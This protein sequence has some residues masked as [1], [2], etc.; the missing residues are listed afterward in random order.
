MTVVVDASVV[1]KWLLPEPGRD[2]ALRLLDAQVPLVSC[3]LL[4]VEVLAVLAKR[5]RR[6]ELSLGHARDAAG[7]LRETMQVVELEPS[8]ALLDAAFELGLALR[9]AVY[10]CLYLACAQRRDAPLLTADGVLAGKAMALPIRVVTL[11]EVGR[12]LDA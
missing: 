4:P 5:H 12:L 3:D 9:H 10:D 11:A 8:A 7:L 2:L 6:G 1:A